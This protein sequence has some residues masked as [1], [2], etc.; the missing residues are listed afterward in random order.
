VLLTYGISFFVK[1]SI[2]QHDVAYSD[3][4]S[5]NTVF[6]L[7]DA[8]KMNPVLLAIHHMCVIDIKS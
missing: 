4:S 7:N 2:V 6:S 8:S 1:D 3:H 5:I